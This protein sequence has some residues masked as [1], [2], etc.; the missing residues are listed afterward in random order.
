MHEYP[1]ASG[2]VDQFLSNIVLGLYDMARADSVGNRFPIPVLSDPASIHAVLG[3]QAR[4]VKSLG[5]L[6]AWGTSRFNANGAEWEVRRALTQRA[7]L[8]AGAEQNAGAVR[9]IYEARL[10]AA[11]DDSLESI[12]RALMLAASETFFSAFN[13]D[14]DLVGLL[15]LFE[16]ARP[17]IKRLQFFTWHAPSASERNALRDEA[18]EITRAFERLVRQ[19]PTVLD[20]VASFDAASGLSEFDAFHELLMNFFAAIETTAATL[21]FAVDRLGLGASVQN[22]LHEE[23]LHEGDVYLN[24][25]IDETLRY[26]PTVPFVVRE[27]VEDT[28]LGGTVLAKGH[29]FL[30]SI[31]GLHHDVR[32]W[33]EPDVFDSSRKEFLTSTYDRRS[34]LPFLAGPRMCGGARLARL[35][36]REGLKAFVRT[37]ET[38]NDSEAVGFDYGIT[39]RPR[40]LGRMTF[41]RRS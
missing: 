17:H 13:C 9:K 38:T 18:N 8:S 40:S 22:R 32:K 2:V 41:S 35:E 11:D 10:A 23:A 36:L 1:P 16:R 31:V 34:F 4:F 28:R 6:G 25:F 15:E 7:Y 39:L 30:I 14:A 33:A 3:D 20:L 27:A 12:Q 5:L 37:F 26:F 29:S 24:C 19:S 21:C